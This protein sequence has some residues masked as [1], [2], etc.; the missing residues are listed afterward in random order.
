MGKSQRKRSHTATNI[1]IPQRFRTGNSY[2]SPGRLE[3]YRG[4]SW[5]KQWP[6]YKGCRNPDMPSMGRNR[7]NKNHNWSAFSLLLLCLPLAKPK[8]R[9]G[10]AG[11]G[12]DQSEEGR[13]NLEGE[14]VVSNNWYS[15]WYLKRKTGPDSSYNK[16]RFSSGTI[17]VEKKRP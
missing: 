7:N 14:C 8:E 5:Q 15:Q 6:S 10:K 12:T 11:Q 13:I 4:L 9:E 2:T 1:P 17:A 3:C 16:N